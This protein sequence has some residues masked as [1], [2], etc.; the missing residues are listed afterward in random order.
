MKKS[1]Y[2]FL[3]IF[4][5]LSINGREY[6]CEIENYSFNIIEKYFMEE[7]DFIQN[8][9]KV[10]YTT[11]ESRVNEYQRI[12]EA[13]FKDNLYVKEEK[14]S[15][16]AYSENINYSVKFVQDNEI[17]KVEIVIL[18][19]DKTVNKINLEKL[20]KNIKS[21][22]T[23]DE[24]YFSFIKGKISNDSNEIFNKIEENLYEDSIKVA[25]I[26]NGYSIKATMKDNEMINI[27]KVNYD[28][29][30]YLII[31]TPIIFITY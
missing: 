27:G 7:C 13:L 9:L 2:I 24:R 10:E 29:G 26:N 6:R 23:I 14:N 31:G 30:S 8:G 12:L 17:L 25:E 16:S 20:V 15:I 5:L 11:R 21:S 4:S 1:F 28:T 22:E 18:N 19:T 3:L